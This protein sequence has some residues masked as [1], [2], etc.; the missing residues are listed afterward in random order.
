[1]SGRTITPAKRATAY[2]E[3][4]IQLVKTGV[5]GLDD[6]LHG[7]L[8]AGAVYLIEG[9]SGT[10][11]TTLGLQFALEGAK[12]G[13]SVLYV[14]LSETQRDLEA[15]A[16]SHGWDLEKVHILQA[17]APQAKAA[18]MFY[19]SEVELGELMTRLK[20]EIQ[21]IGPSRIVIDSLSEIRLMAEGP[22][23]YRREV[24]GLRQFQGILTGE[25]IFTG[26]ASQLVQA[27]D[28]KGRGSSEG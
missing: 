5:S 22:L 15:V 13:E 8:T 9:T 12:Q 28:G 19:P 7:G 17:M 27:K 26:A 20:E 24:L 6:V 4:D 23:R 25:P 11:K 3:N 16:H 18:T 2:K 10:G 21:R 1:L 14:T